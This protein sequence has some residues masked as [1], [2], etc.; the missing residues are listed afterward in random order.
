MKRSTVATGIAV[1]RI[2]AGWALTALLAVAPW[3][4]S[5]GLAQ[6]GTTPSPA[7]PGGSLHVRS[8]PSGALVTLD[9]EYRWRGTTPWTL[10]RDLE[11]TYRVSAEVRGYERWSRTLSFSPGDVR[12]LEIQLDRKTALKAAVRSA[13]VPGWGQRYNDQPTKGWVLLSG[14]ALA[15]GGLAWSHIVYSGRVDDFEDA[16]DAYL[17]EK[18][19]DALSGRREKMEREAEQADD[20]YT[21]RK[22]WLIGLGAVYAASVIDALFLSPGSSEGSF[23]LA[24]VADSPLALS[25]SGT[26]D[27]L[28]M[29]IAVHKKL[30]GVR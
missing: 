23:S 20:A 17:R 19:V 15:G 14:A 9:G 13:L 29:G 5:P 12:E 4:A 28:V 1:A 24:P 25:V 26:P 21:L 16:R 6:S 27:G 30:G 11:G 22:G 3:F 7:I 18:N 2:V 8:V 10:E